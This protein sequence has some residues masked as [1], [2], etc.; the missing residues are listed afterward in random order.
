MPRLLIASINWNKHQSKVSIE[1]QNE[2]LDFEINPNFQEVSRLFVLSLEDDVHRASHTRYY[3]PAV[4]IKDYN[5][6]IK[7]KY[8]F[9]QL[10]NNDLRTFMNTWKNYS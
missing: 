9:D 1:I 7:G 5:F 6:R 3:L 4:E 10:V 2:Y 8:F